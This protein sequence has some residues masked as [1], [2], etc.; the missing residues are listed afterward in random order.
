MTESKK[1]G[2]KLVDLIVAAAEAKLAGD[3]IAL[4]VS[5]ASS[6]TDWLVICSGEAAPQ[7]RAI[8]DAI[9]ESLKKNR[10]K[11][12]KWEGVTGSGWLVLD[13]GSVVVHVMAAAE[14]DYYR[15]ED[16]WGKDAVVY[17]Y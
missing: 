1:T 6:L 7:L 8:V 2:R 15:L 13:L 9:A 16:L 11:K 4:D 17:H 3:I 5:R 12:Y 14:R 10:L